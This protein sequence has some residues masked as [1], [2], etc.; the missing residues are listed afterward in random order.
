MGSR[1]VHHN[2][3]NHQHYFHLVRKLSRLPIDFEKQSILK[4]TM[5]LDIDLRMSATQD[6]HQMTRTIHR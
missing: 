6:G 4:L 1:C 5:H 2:F 3:E